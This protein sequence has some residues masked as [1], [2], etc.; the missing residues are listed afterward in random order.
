MN[1]GYFTQL[2]A[3]AHNV[4]LI[5]NKIVTTIVLIVTFSLILTGCTG[6]NEPK[7]AP[8]PE[9]VSGIVSEIPWPDTEFTGYVIQDYDGNEIGSG[10]LLVRKTMD[11]YNLNQRYVFEGTLDR[12][13]MTNVRIDNLKPLA[14]TITRPEIALS[15]VVIYLYKEDGTLTIDAATKEG[16]QQTTI[17]VPEDAYDYYELPFMLRAMPFKIGY[18]ATFTNVI[19]N[20]AE[21]QIAT[22][23]VVGEEELQVPA[24]NFDTYKVEFTSDGNKKYFWYAQEKPHYLVKLDDGTGIIL[25]EE[26]E[27]EL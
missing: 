6:N 5:M 8:E 20:R 12:I 27:E 16:S 1:P 15:P 25:L 24:G 14:G 21:K 13:I 2:R 19:V 9:P 10:A 7:P 11:I 26:I 17:T 23:T 4:K 22:V 3:Q 18:T